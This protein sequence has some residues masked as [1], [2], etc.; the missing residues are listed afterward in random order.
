[1]PYADGTIGWASCTGWSS[2]GGNAVGSIDWALKSGVAWYVAGADVPR[3]VLWQNRK[4]TGLVMSSA[5]MAERHGGAAYTHCQNHH[6]CISPPD[7]LDAR[8]AHG[9]PES[10][11]SSPRRIP[12]LLPP[13]CFRNG[14][15]VLEEREKNPLHHRRQWMDHRDSPTTWKERKSYARMC[16]HQERRKVVAKELVR[17]PRVELGTQADST[18]TLRGD[19]IDG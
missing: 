8:N 1:M 16:A 6:S 10:M 13:S 11:L 15:R 17:Q 14:K 3:E 5:W 12:R 19:A 18:V 7:C 2:G 4:A 9:W